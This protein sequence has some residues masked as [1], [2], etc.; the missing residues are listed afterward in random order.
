MNTVHNKLVL[1]PAVFFPRP[2][3]SHIKFKIME[4]KTEENHSDG[5]GT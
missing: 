4:D 2:G 5:F 1:K 3:N